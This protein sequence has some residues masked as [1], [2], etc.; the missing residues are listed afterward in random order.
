MA[1]LQSTITEMK[2]RGIASDLS[3]DKASPGDAFEWLTDRSDEITWGFRGTLPG[4]FV[5]SGV[6]KFGV[7]TVHFVSLHEDD[8]DP[9]NDSNLTEATADNCTLCLQAINGN[10]ASFV[11]L[12]IAQS[13]AE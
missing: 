13:L 9:G 12:R 2:S 4:H 3:Y 11:A 10:S 8:F 1:N 5:S 6:A 7:E